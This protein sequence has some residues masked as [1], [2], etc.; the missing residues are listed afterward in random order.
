MAETETHWRREKW[1]LAALAVALLIRVLPFI[2]FPQGDCVR[3]ECIYRSVAQRILDGEGLTTTSK[4]WLPAPGY[5]YLLALVKTLFGA[6]FVT[7]IV[8]IP[9]A[10]VS[11]WTMFAI[12]EKVSGRKVGIV[13]AWLFA[14]HPTL[15]YFVGTLW[16]ETVYVFCLL[17][18][19]LW[20]FWTRE[21]DWYRGFAPGLALG[22]ATLFRG[23]A[24][25]LPPI[26]ALAVLWPEEGFTGL[27]SLGRAVKQRWTH[28]LAL[29][30]GW[31]VMITPYSM[32]ASSQHGGFMITDA[33]VGHV[34]F[35][36]NNDF[37]P[38]TFDYGNGML[39]PTLYG[40]WL[41]LGRL[42]CDRNQLPVISSKCEVQQVRK[43]IQDNP[44]EFF[45]RIPER[46]AQLVNPHSFLTRHIRWGYWSTSWAGG[47]PWWIKEG[48]VL[49]VMLASYLVMIGGTIGAFARAR[50]PYA[51]MAV[52][53][54][55]YTAATISLM[56][57]M[58][59]FRLPLEPLWMVFL[60]MLLVEPRE[61]I[62]ALLAS[63]P[64]A[65]MAVVVVPVLF[66]LT[67]RYLPTGFPMF[68]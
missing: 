65:A 13:C 26:F 20:V 68:W 15:A 61:S 42:P 21:G 31:L 40:R 35:L 9:M 29:G 16:I 50:G 37:P 47:M 53:T 48:L 4:G 46:L 5:P 57:G 49:F 63:N 43:W 51:V 25:Y 33:T 55:L 64:R 66:A 7:K 32:S 30:L 22:M 17:F 19:V 24:T 58:T 23:V 14:L 39:T 59:R 34:L 10:L 6:F 3:D 28:A 11:T 18:A 8:Q 1:L 56:Y 44:E 67:L 60:A 12:G 38:L 45:G 2:F 54:V 52:G 41:R 27:G 36:G 62:K